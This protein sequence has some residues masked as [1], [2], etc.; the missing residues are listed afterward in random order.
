VESHGVTALTLVEFSST[1]YPQCGPSF[2]KASENTR[3]TALEPRLSAEAAERCIGINAGVYT[4]KLVSASGFALSHNG[5]EQLVVQD[6]VDLG[7]VGA[8]MGQEGC[9]L[10]AL[11]IMQDPMA[12]G[13]PHTAEKVKHYL[14][15]LA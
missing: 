2:A 7:Q 14:R 1:P 4:A 12:N 5:K 9:Q 11:V 8:C 15:L 13:F 6:R 10:V 3:T